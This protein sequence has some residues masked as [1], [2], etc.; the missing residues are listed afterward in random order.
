MLL[1]CLTLLQSDKTV[2]QSNCG[3]DGVSV[4]LFRSNQIC[5]IQKGLYEG[6]T[7]V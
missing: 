3:D 5:G 7:A 2:C 4:C 6:Q 1:M